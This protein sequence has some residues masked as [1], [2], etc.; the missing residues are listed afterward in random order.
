MGRTKKEFIEELIQ[1]AQDAV[2]KNEL[3]IAY[4]QTNPSG[5]EKKDTVDIKACEHSIE[6]DKSYIGFLYGQLDQD[7]A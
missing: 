5:D 4:R 3:V 1:T 6:K 7:S 2:W